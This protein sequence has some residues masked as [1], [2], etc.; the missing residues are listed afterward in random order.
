[1]PRSLHC[2]VLDMSGCE[3]KPG[4]KRERDSAK[5]QAQGAAIKKRSNELA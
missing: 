1:M 3:C 5:H 2:V 4:A